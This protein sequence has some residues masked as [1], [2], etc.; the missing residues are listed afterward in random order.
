MAK[1]GKKDRKQIGS[2]D[3]SQKPTTDF[4]FIILIQNSLRKS[5]CKVDGTVNKLII[6]H[7]TET[8]WIDYADDTDIDDYNCMIA[9]L[10]MNIF[11]S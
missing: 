9:K 11:Q 10:D 5:A 2:K 1:I 8:A 3:V 4:G 6:R 7:S